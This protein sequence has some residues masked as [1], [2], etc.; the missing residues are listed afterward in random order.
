MN[1]MAKG[2][3]ERMGLVLS[4]CIIFSIIFRCTLLMLKIILNHIDH[5]GLSEQILLVSTYL[6]SLTCN[7]SIYPLLVVGNELTA[8][9]QASQ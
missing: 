8:K 1:M 5:M 9:L 3:A 6:T 2:E 7:S 4:P